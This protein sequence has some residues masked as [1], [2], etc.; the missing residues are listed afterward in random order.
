MG[1]NFLSKRNE[2][3]L[4]REWRNIILQDEISL[5]YGILHGATKNSLG[6]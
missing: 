3:F 2:C 6:W 1:L 4:G 5:G